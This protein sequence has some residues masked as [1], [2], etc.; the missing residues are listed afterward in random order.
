MK[1]IL[2]LAIAAAI[3]A[4]PSAWAQGEHS[5]TEAPASKKSALDKATFEAYIRHLELLVPEVQLKVNDPKPSVLP[6]F[7]Q[8]TVH[9]SYQGNPVKDSYYFVSKDGKYIIRGT[10]HDIN[11][12]PF[13]SDINLLTTAS[14]PSLGPA[15]AP[16]HIVMFSD[17]E[18]PMCRDE[19][20]SLRENLLKA[21]PTQVR[22]WF[23]DYPLSAIH[24]W[25]M[26]AAKAGRC[27]YHQN[28]EAFWNY[29]D[30]VYD[31]QGDITPQ[32]VRQM[33]ND[34]AAGAKLDTTKLGACMDSPATQAEIEES[35][36]EARALQIDATPTLF[37]N[38]RRLVGS[39]DWQ[40]L[41]KLIEFELDYQKTAS[42]NESCCTVAVPMVAKKK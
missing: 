38:G 24:P 13:Q 19:A 41:Q 37:L 26:A 9:L 6:G 40:N 16:I 30:W 27:V 8:I 22:L 32:N 33:I 25:A 14:Q 1:S 11:Q 29:F 42:A 3:C 31:H 20:K 10:I 7:Y 36:E 12:N 21:F 23:K 34:F 28:A 15:N 5:K 39:I 17:F 18:C 35:S 2:F 4:G